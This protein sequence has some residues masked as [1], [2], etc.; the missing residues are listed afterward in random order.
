MFTKT[1]TT[2]LEAP[3]IDIWNQMLE[4]FYLHFVSQN[5]LQRG[6]TCANVEGHPFQQPPLYEANVVVLPITF[7]K[8]GWNLQLD[9]VTR[10]NF[11]FRERPNTAW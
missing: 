8:L 1:T 7:F 9:F 10:V 3:Y 5:S 4:I 6:E 11:L 2:F